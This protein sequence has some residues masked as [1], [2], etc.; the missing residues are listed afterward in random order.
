MKVNNE[1]REWV[2]HSVTKQYI[3]ELDKL[4]TIMLESIRAIEVSNINEIVKSI[5]IVEGIDRAKGVITSIK[6]T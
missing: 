5:G 3:L 6:E 1:T 2:N 4:R